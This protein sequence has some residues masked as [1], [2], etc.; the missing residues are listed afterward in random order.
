MV[1]HVAPAGCW[2]ARVEGIYQHLCTCWPFAGAVAK[3]PNPAILAVFLIIMETLLRRCARLLE[4]LESGE[5]GTGKG[6]VWCL[7]LESA[8]WG[9][10]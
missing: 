6:V 4:Q 1:G 10:S 9:G 5:V 8:I 3:S 2:G 7:C